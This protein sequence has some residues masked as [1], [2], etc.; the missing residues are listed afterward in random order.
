[1]RDEIHA[2]ISATLRDVV[3]LFPSMKRKEND[4][5]VCD[6]PTIDAA[7]YMSFVLF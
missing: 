1:M 6:P 2:C 4:G 3:V 7:M 5:T